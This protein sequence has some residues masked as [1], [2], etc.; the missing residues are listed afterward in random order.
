MNKRPNILIITC[1]QLSSTMMSCT[2]N[3]YLK[4]PNIDRIARRGVRF[5]HAL[6]A[7]PMCVPSRFALYTGLLPSTIGLRS[8]DYDDMSPCSED[9]LSKGMGHYFKNIG[10]D[11]LFGGKESFPGFRAVDL[12][13]TY[14]S[15]DDRGMLADTCADYLKRK[16]DKPFLM[17]AS[18]VNP[19]D[20]CLFA[21]SELGTDEKSKKLLAAHK[22]EVDIINEELEND[23]GIDFYPP[24]P[25]NYMPQQDE[26]EI[27]GDLLASR[28]FK[29]RARAEW[30][31]V[32]WRRHRYLYARL[33]ERVDVHVGTLLDALYSGPN[34]SDT[35]VIFTS[36]HGD[37][38]SSHKLE[39]KSILYKEAIEVPFII[40]WPDILPEG[41]VIDA[42]ISNGL[43]LLPTLLDAVGIQKPDDLPGN[44]IIDLAKGN[45]DIL[46]EYTP[47]EGNV[48]KALWHKDWL[49]CCYDYGKNAEQLYDMKNDPGQNKNSIEG[50]EEILAVFKAR[51]KEIWN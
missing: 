5:T 29:E 13:F 39:H 16:H 1:D 23:P 12:G 2:G 21:I 42:A 46:R 40:S 27:I 14:I 11:T 20:I 7:N 49:Y 18:F 36:D 26:P 9:V 28:A 3:P 51:A 6:S 50:N 33:T 45:V 24:L 25:D 35:I 38:D 31:D 15:K 4:T 8:N 41:K 47:I 10:Y 44:S 37:H 32:E 43:D 19:H 48:S 22:F 30:T 17:A 34:G